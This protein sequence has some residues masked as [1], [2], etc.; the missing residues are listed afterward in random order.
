MAMKPML[1]ISP[2][3]VTGGMLLGSAVAALCFFFLERRLFDLI[4]PTL[5]LVAKYV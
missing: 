1:G 3:R 4:D 2:F 5:R